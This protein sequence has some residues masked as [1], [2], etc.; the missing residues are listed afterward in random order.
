MTARGKARKRALDVLYE[1]DVRG[2]DP[3]ATLQERLAQRDPPIAA[4][5]VDLVEG[6]L[7]HRDRADEL[8][9]RYAVD[10]TLERMPAVD[11]NLLRLGIYELMWGDVP[12]AV[13]VSEAVELAR[14]LSTDHS[15]SFVNGVL[16]RILD[17]KADLLAEDA[18]EAAVLQGVD[19]PAGVGGE[20]PPV[21]ELLGEGTRRGVV[22]HGE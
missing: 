1:A 17:E 2:T 11:R 13:A 19:S 18:A 10:W 4:Y 7:A 9:R 8:I 12:D 15:P 3:R 5:A 21:D 22:D 14:S 20:D 16:G 6:V